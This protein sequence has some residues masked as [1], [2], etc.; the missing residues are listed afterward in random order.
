[1]RASMDDLALPP[2]QDA[3]LWDYLT[4]AAHSLVNVLPEQAIGDNLL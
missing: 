2:E 3:I 1:M 4:M